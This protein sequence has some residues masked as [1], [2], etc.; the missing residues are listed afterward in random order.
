MLFDLISTAIQ[1]NL[2]PTL[3]LTVQLEYP[4]FDHFELKWVIIELIIESKKLNQNFFCN[5]SFSISFSIIDLNPS[6]RLGQAHRPR[7]V[8]T[9]Y[10][11]VNDCLN[12]QRRVSQM[13][14]EEQLKERSVGH[15]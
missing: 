2:K 7:L 10:K 6:I 11:I 5:I 13:W 3:F 14:P 8:L 1:F 12:I 15:L 4:V 9:N